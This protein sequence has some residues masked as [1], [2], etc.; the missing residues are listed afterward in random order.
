MS[1]GKDFKLPRGLQMLLRDLGLS[2]DDVLRRSRLPEDLFRQPEVRLTTAEYFRFWDALLA[3]SNDDGLP[4]RIADAITAEGFDPPLFATLC[5]PNLMI[6]LE[7]LSQ[8]KRLVCP[9]VLDVI[10]DDHGITAEFRWINTTALPPVSLLN[11]EA[12]FI[13]RIARMATREH[14]QPLRV[15]SPKLPREPELYERYFGVPVQHHDALRISFSE[16]DAELP[17][18]TANE[19]MWQIFEPELRK[20]LSQIE[21][22]ATT[23]DRVRAVLFESLPS[24]RAT[25]NEVASRLALSGRTL[26]RR[27]QA[28]GTNYQTVLN[29]TRE[30]LARHYLANTHM[31]CAEISFL[32]GYEEPNSF[33]RAFHDWTGESP[34]N[35]RLSFE[36]ARRSSS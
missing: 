23:V 26:Q 1:S 2:V 4:I 16:H 27:L 14:I 9:M 35:A 34:E 7:R 15:M 10:R 19:S 11:M 22:N 3:T 29:Q 12:T 30:Q 24:G 31:S 18:L 28:E 33:S 5:S 20:R 36:L 8:Y 21:D 6:A 32:L 13:V 17:F 25:I